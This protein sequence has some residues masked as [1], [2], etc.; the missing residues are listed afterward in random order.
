MYFRKS[1]VRLIAIAIC[2]AGAVAA[3]TTTTTHT[4]TF[5]FGPVGIGSTESAQ[6]NVLNNAPTSSSGTAASC[7]GSISFAG[8]TGTAIGTAT[9][10]TVTSGQIFSVSVPFSKVATSGSRAEIAGS[11]ALTFTSGSTAPCSLTSSFE[12]F[13][14]SS[15]V[16]HVHLDGSQQSGGPVGFGH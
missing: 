3:Q 9:S 10:F 5:N 2:M 12:T 14:T 7:T 13:D 8:S 1:V 4:Q 6:I 16:T 11:V 15:G